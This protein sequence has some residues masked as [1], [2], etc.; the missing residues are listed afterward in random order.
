MLTPRKALAKRAD[1]ISISSDT[2][3]GAQEISSTGREIKL[4]EVVF[5]YAF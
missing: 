3:K 1:S 2:K 4:F 5:K